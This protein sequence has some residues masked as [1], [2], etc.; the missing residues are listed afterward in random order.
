MITVAKITRT[1]DACPSQWEGTTDADKAVYVRYRWGSLSISIGDTLTQAIRRE[2]PE[3]S[4][5][6]KEIGEG[7]DGYL[8]YDELKQHTRGV[9]SWPEFEFEEVYR[10]DIHS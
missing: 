3:N 8:T 1:C 10:Y 2:G 5:F 6:E 9:I 7:L 4:V